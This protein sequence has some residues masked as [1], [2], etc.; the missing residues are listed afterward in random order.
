MKYIQ[1]LN[2]FL[3]AGLILTIFAF[4][5][6]VYAHA[7][8]VLY[9][10]ENESVIEKVPGQI[11]IHYSERVDLEA[12]S[13]EVF[14]PDGSRVDKNN[15][16]VD[17]NDPRLFLIS[18]DT[19]KGDGTYTVSWKVLSRDDGHFSK[20]AFI[21]SVGKETGSS[22]S[23]TDQFQVVYRSNIEEATTI[24][25]EFL[26]LGLLIGLLLIHLF[27]LKSL[28]K[29]QRFGNLFQFDEAYQKRFRT[30]VLA[31]VFLIVLG[32][33]SYVV[34]KT[35]DLQSFQ[36]LS[37]SEA[38]SS[39][40][41]TMGGS[42]TLYRT[43]LAILFLVIFLSAKRKIFNNGESWLVGL[44]S[45]LVLIA[46]F[47]GRVSHA[48]ASHFLPSL[49]IFI[50]FL[51][52]FFKTFWVGALATLVFMILP[53]ARKAGDQ[54]SLLIST[55]TSKL[56][57]IAFG[58]VG[59]SGAY[60][61]WLDLKDPSFVLTSMWG[62][63]FI[64]LSLV[65]GA[66]LL[67]RLFNQFYI[68]RKRYLKWA[69]YTLP[70]ELMIGIVLLFVTSFIVIT[71][72]PVAKQ[73][74]LEKTT[75]SQGTIISL[76]EHRFEDDKFLVTIL[77]EK[78]G[79]PVEVKTMTITLLN[80]EKG[81]GPIV[82]DSERRFEGGYVFSEKALSP[83]GSWKIDISASRPGQYDSATSFTLSYPKEIDDSHTDPNR[84]TLDF[85]AIQS[86]FAALGVAI[87]A[88]LLYG[89]SKNLLRSNT[90]VIQNQQ[91]DSALFNFSAK[92]WVTSFAL[93][94]ISSFILWHGYSNILKN[95]FQ[96]ICEQ[97]K[98]A[99]HQMAPTRDGKATSQ[100]SQIGCMTFSGAF[101]FADEREYKYFMSP[102][103][104]FVEMQ[105]PTEI[106]A[107]FPTNLVFS[108]KDSKG[109]PI[110]DLTVTH[111]RILHVITVG[112]D[113]RTFDHIHPENAEPITAE[114]KHSGVYRVPHTFTKSG[115]YIVSV[116]FTIRSKNFTKQFFVDV[117]GSPHLEA[118][119]EENSWDKTINGY[120][121]KFHTVPGGE[122]T[123]GKQVTLN[124][125]IT[126]NGTPVKDLKP[127][128]GA[129]MHLAIV[130][131]DLSKF[132][133]THGEVHLA[134][135]PQ[136]APINTTTHYHPAPP[137]IFGPN[138][139]AHV[140]FPEPGLYQVFSEFS[141]EG[142]T[143]LTNFNVRVE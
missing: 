71:S 31:G 50:M 1:K 6:Y 22:L 56:I 139:E 21:F 101:F 124:Y 93:I 87:F 91:S 70:L 140:I 88:F 128:L 81:I 18:I 85:F 94:T 92:E 96:K 11:K 54:V 131:A 120:R 30:L 34:V 122:I 76:A 115:Q 107:G 15:A 51:Q 43:G 95:S 90:E 108:I 52:V 78:T 83:P 65:G 20:G 82:V 119:K 133:H 17:P 72:P 77:D 27:V 24:F 29:D 105:T 32:T 4:P 69:S 138:I 5:N 58:I 63:R 9:E 2:L 35:I 141:H 26:G 57:S 137:K 143:I 123:A 84:R 61:V 99:W 102:P 109:E 134:G 60:I 25:I 112:E 16:S 59:I 114:I 116:D 74:I 46:I 19:S 129:A 7:T 62:T 13:L 68:D 127:Y 36:N 132:V 12:S 125:E 97:D 45:L 10:P 44:L 8:P 126:K 117:K 64:I 86:I 121:V 73:P 53:L 100:I 47:R 28:R 49:S 3:L 67:V 48:A 113:L 104:A 111:E 103:D 110:T 135:T 14:G 130:K 38:L 41:P 118:A 98:N 42:F 33:L 75:A 80:E 142:K 136:N 79:D 106:Q 23:N 66:L 55:S 89:F 37:F 40:M 39:F